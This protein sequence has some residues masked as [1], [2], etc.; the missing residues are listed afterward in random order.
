MVK[1]FVTCM[2]FTRVVTFCKSKRRSEDDDSQDDGESNLNRIELE[3][4]KTLSQ[5]LEQKTLQAHE[6]ECLSIQSLKQVGH[7]GSQ[8]IT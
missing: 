5:N 8:R 3:N 1:I 2:C 7:Q 4:E 6:S